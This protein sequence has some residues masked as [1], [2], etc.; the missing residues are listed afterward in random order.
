MPALQAKSLYDSLHNEKFGGDIDQYVTDKLGYKDKD[1]LYDHLSAEQI[2]GVALAI[3][4]LDAGSGFILGDMTGV[5]K[6]RQGAA[7]IRYAVRR[8]LK[9]VYFTAKPQLFSD[10]YRDLSDIGSGELRPFIFAST[11]DGDITT[12]DDDG[13][14]TTVHAVPSSSEFDRVM[15]AIGKDGKLPDGYDFV[16]CTYSQVQNGTSGWAYDNNGRRIRTDKK[17]KSASSRK[18]AESGE[19][20]RNAIEYLSRDTFVIF[21][22]SHLA[23][24]ESDTGLFLQECL[25]CAKG[26]VFMSATFAKRP[27]NMPFYAQNTGLSESGLESGDLVKAVAFGGLPLQE[28]MSQQLVKSGQMVR[29]ERDFSGVSIDWR[30]CAR[31]SQ[32]KQRARYNSVVPILNRFQLI[33]EMFIKPAMK[34]AAELYAGKNLTVTRTPMSSVL[35]PMFNQVMFA[36]KTEE[37][38]QTAIAELQQGRKPVI[39]YYYTADSVFDKLDGRRKAEPFE[40]DYTL[41]LMQYLDSMLEIRVTTKEGNVAKTIRVEELLKEG[42]RAAHPL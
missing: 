23:A 2:E 26:S 25:E 8:G 33:E 4:Q 16:L 37:I 13:R 20:R 41:A 27:D 15:A 18:A 9:P 7:I 29:R 40:D 10:V 5:G 1:E 32:E 11:K 22:E 24:G 36:L 38:V 39:S 21:D 17:M 14:L 31:S 35:F 19:R 28:V 34:T 12:S 6:G 42:E 3:A 30:T